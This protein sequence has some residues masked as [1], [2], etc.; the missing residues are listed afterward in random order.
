MVN[1]IMRIKR[2]FTFHHLR[3]FVYFFGCSLT[4]WE[5]HVNTSDQYF[6]AHDIIM[7]TV[8]RFAWRSIFSSHVEHRFLW[9][10]VQRSHYQPWVS[11]APAFSSIQ[12]NSCSVL[13]PSFS[14]GF[15]ETFLASIGLSQDQYKDGK[16]LGNSSEG[17]RAVF[18]SS[19]FRMEAGEKSLLIQ[20]D[21]V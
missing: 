14:F 21:R 12:A 8:F 6:L 4:L 10:K 20:S 9:R 18:N 5:T 2:Y 13:C 7:L 17:E 1:N 11:R 3:F 19:T 15:N 16:W